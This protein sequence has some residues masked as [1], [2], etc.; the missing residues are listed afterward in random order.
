MTQGDLLRELTGEQPGSGANGIQTP[1][2]RRRA[3]VARSA[4]QLRTLPQSRG[5]QDL[6]TV[7]DPLLTFDE[8][9]LP[10]EIRHTFGELHLELRRE[11]FLVHHGVAPRRTFLFAGPP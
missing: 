2:A 8:L 3:S 7:R 6:L 11:D 1:A 10:E 5:D 4:H 9:L